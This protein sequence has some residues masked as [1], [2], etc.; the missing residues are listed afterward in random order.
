[1]RAKNVR[2]SIQRKEK[3]FKQ[4][5]THILLLIGKVSNRFSA[6][7]GLYKPARPPN[8]KLVFDQKRPET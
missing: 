7:A 8:Q 5:K 6:N 3:H 1:V 2:Q 4:P